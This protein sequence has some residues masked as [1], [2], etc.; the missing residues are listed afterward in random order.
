MNTQEPAAGQVVRP[1]QPGDRDAVYD[2]CVRTGRASQDA[3][4]LY[5]TDD[6]IPDIYAGPYLMIEPDLAF[7]LDN[8]RRAVGYVIGTADT[9]EFVRAYRERWLPLMRQRYQP[10]PD[11]AQTG[12]ERQLANLF[13]PERMIRPELAPYPAH[14]HI[15]LLPDYQGGGFGRALVTRFLAA[16]AA[17]GAAWAHLA[18][19]TSNTAAQGFYTRLGWTQI[20]ASDEGPW[21]FMVKS[22][23]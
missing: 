18:V 12:E 17:H 4:G 20:R 1:Y 21:T 8:G 9:P 22:T 2:V 3:R 14:L 5:S 16:A 6:L 11:P 10:P 23:T 7:V 19:Y 15:N 13:N